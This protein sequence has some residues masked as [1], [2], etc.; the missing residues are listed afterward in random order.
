[1]PV[2]HVVAEENV[3]AEGFIINPLQARHC[4][5]AGG[6]LLDMAGDVD[7]RTHL[8]LDFA[9]HCA[10][11]EAL[12]VGSAVCRRDDGQLLFAALRPEA[13][14]RLGAVDIGARRLAWLAVLRARRES[15]SPSDE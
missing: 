12:K 6:R 8:N 15:G 2:R 9:E 5:I 1:V 7:P 10:V 13:I 3:D 14:A 11:A 4:V